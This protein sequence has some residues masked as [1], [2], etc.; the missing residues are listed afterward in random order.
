MPTYVYR[1]QKCS[2]TIE[3]SRRID[4]RDYPAS[5]PK[6]GLPNAKRELAAPNIVLRGS[7][8]HNQE[9]NKTGRRHGS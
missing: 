8:W 4:E 1:C 2:E 6:C 7:G 5:C 3:L 9:Y